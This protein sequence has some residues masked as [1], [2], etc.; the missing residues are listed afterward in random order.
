MDIQK[1][2]GNVEENLFLPFGNVAGTCEGNFF[3]RIHTATRQQKQRKRAASCITTMY[4]TIS[5]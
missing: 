4:A 2:V 5:H 3:F 1:E